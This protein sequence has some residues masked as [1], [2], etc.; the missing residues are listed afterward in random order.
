LAG[1]DLFEKVA[2]LHQ[3]ELGRVDGEVPQDLEVPDP[4]IRRIRSFGNSV[5]RLRFANIRRFRLYQ[6]A[7]RSALS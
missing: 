1:V 2:R 4:T 6:L 3:G 7:T 5:M